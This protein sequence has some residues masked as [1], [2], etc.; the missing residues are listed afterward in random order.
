L[1]GVVERFSEERAG[2]NDAENAQ[3]EDSDQH[4]KQRPAHRV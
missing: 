2:H 3:H 4:K 1:S